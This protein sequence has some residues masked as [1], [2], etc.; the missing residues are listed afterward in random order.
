MPTPISAKTASPKI[1]V[2]IPC[3]VLKSMKRIE[4]S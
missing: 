1:E 3:H 4:V 2:A